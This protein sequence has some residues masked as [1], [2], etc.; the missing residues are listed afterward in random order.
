MQLPHFSFK[1]KS[2]FSPSTRVLTSFMQV[3]FKLCMKGLVGVQATLSNFFNQKKPKRKRSSII[4]SSQELYLLVFIRK[5][6]EVP[7]VDLL[8]ISTYYYKSSKVTVS[9]SM[10][11]HTSLSFTVLF[12]RIDVLPKRLH[13][14]SFHNSSTKS[15]Q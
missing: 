12:G 8:H 3:C 13:L 6:L 5:L 10:V 14:C 9:S 11:Q 1:H 4:L 2:V 15:Q 7:L